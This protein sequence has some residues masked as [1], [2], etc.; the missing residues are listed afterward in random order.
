MKNV[1]IGLFVLVAAPMLY[2][3]N[4]GPGLQRINNAKIGIITNRLNLTQEQAT[5]FWP[6]YNEYDAKQIDIRKSIRRSMNEINTLTATDA[7]IVE[8]L[9]KQMDLKQR[10]VDLEKEYMS[11]FLKVLNARQLAELYKAELQF[12]Q[13]LLKKLNQDNKPD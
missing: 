13:I 1:M 3:Q 6:I 4:G 2:A 7:Q 9:K 11:R 10:E 5:Q 12:T 8:A